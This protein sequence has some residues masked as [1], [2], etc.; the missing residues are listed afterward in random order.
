MTV[1]FYKNTSDNNDVHKK[2][3]APIETEAGVLRDEDVNVFEPIITVKANDKLFQY[4][5]CYIPAFSRYYFFKEPITIHSKGLYMVNL[6]A[7]VLM[8]FQGTPANGYSDGWLGNAGYVDTSK[9]YGNFYLHDN[10]M[11]VQQNTKITTHKIYNT[12]FSGN[13]SSIVMNCLNVSAV[14]PP[15]A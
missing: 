5:Y 15:E 8:N 12:P 14:A 11:P 3:V 4:N 2:L 1:I 10:S 9:N 13:A 6:H 7:D